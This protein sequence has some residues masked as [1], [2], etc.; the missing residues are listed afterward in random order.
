MWLSCSHEAYG[1]AAETDTKKIVN[2]HKLKPEQ[3]KCN[4]WGMQTKKSPE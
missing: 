4:P 1:L 3:L 2:K